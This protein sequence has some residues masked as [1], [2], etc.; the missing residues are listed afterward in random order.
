MKFQ[1]P[2]PL[3]EVAEVLNC[4]YKGPHDLSLTG[5]NEIHKVEAGDITFTD[6]PK[7]YKKALNS[8]ATAVLINSEEQEPAAGKG[9]LISE[10]PFR[11]YNR[12]VKHFRLPAPIP[13]GKFTVGKSVTI[14][15]NTQVHPGVVIGNFVKIGRNCI[16]YPNVVIYD[17]TTIGDNV[18][19][20]ANSVLGADAFYFKNRNTHHDK[21]ISCGNVIVEEDVEIGASCT[22]D[23][24][25]SG[26]TVI[27]KG[28]KLDN[29]IHVGHGA[30]IGKRC[31]IAAQ[32]GIGG[33][34]IIEDDVIIWGQAGITKDIRI[35][36][37]AVISAQAGVSKSLP[38]G[39]LY[40][41]SPARDA[42]T[43]YREMAALRMMSANPENK[44]D[45]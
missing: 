13:Q 44:P 7:Y 33:K 28:S 4:R 5:I 1:N 36:K 22:I 8:A 35:G 27:G 12:L 41:G 23:K 3:R 11:D 38:G 20:H 15:E 34:A 32:C 19:I 39:K 16:I 43:A 17:Q 18:V 6:V 37:G 14:A 40:F 42:R 2:Q 45:T 29:H 26:S 25:V 30:I 24:G 10:D 21:L 31:L 9:L